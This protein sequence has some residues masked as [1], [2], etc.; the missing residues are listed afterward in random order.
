MKLPKIKKA[1]P[2]ERYQ[3]SSSPLAQK[4]TQKKLACLVGMKRDELRSLAKYKENYIIRREIEKNG[5][6]RKLVYP[7]GKLR[8]FHEIISFHLKKII[9]PIYLYSPRKGYSQRHNA[10]LHVGQ[11]QFLKV[12]IKQFYPSTTAV[13][14]SAWA[15]AHLK[16]P[17]DVARLF[18]DLVTGDG[19]AFFGSPLTPVLA[20]LV[21]RKMFDEVY[22]RCKKRGLRC[23][24]WVDDLTISGK[25]VPG[26]LLEEI[27]SIIA[28]NG[29]K[30]HKL[31][32]LTGNR[33]VVVTGL[34]VFNV[35]IEPP[36]KHLKQIGVL[37]SSLAAAENLRNTE[38]LTAKLLSVAGSAKYIV[39]SSSP[40]WHKLSNQMNSV[41]Q[42][43]AKKIRVHNE[44]RAKLNSKT[45]S[46]N[47]STSSE[48]VPW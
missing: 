35:G 45:H 2:T 4:M 7:N 16:M 21:H 40:N 1:K 6:I 36:L 19:S 43:L 18:A 11:R 44:M 41:K 46:L 30:S 31:E 14:I 25:F 26:L 10:S 29:L 23:S 22:N 32:Y 17:Q 12:D 24:L 3:I 28:L 33:S 8:R 27:R 48:P 13:Q 37:F 42:K 20:T 39:G 5:K 38:I 34:R 15:T 47:L 9:Q